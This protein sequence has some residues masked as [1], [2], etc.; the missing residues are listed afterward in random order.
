VT[1]AAR[2]RLRPG[3]RLAVPLLVLVAGAPVAS[4][5]PQAARAAPRPRGAGIA[6]GELAWADGSVERAELP[7]K[8]TWRRLEL[9]ER[10]RTGDTFRTSERATARLDFPW[11][12]VGLA[13]SSMLTIPASTVLSTTLEQG[14]A[15][16]AGP[17]RDIVKIRVGDA[18]VRGGG[19][20][21]LHR[22]VGRTSASALEGSFRLRAA[23]RAVEI[24][25]GEGTVVADGRPPEPPA[26]LPPA[27]Q[28][29]H[30]GKDPV[31]VRSGQP[32]E[33]RW[34]AVGPAHHVEVLDLQKDEVL[35][36]R[37][38]TAPPLRVAI[39]WPGTFRWRVSARD[40]RGVEGRPSGDGW[41]CS[42][43][44]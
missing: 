27:P 40:A 14:R 37:E 24:K 15:E 25:A 22:S 23:G 9:G 2:A 5:E 1:A 35:L 4:P 30:P 39:P 33:L 3:L 29:L 28:G 10:L 31:Y 6:I 42:V 11:M 17:G 36:A 21:V 13:P 44:E 20:L 41:I 16:F 12:A 7:A 19:R 34:T 32:I 18:E 43:D 26:P 8:S 38:A